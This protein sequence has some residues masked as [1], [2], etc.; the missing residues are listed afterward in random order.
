MA[1]AYGTI[2]PRK[3]S[4]RSGYDRVNQIPT[5]TLMQPGDAPQGDRADRERERVGEAGIGRKAPSAAR[6]PGLFENNRLVGLSYYS[7]VAAGVNGCATCCRT[8]MNNTSRITSMTKCTQVNKAK[9]PTIIMVI[10]RDT[11][12]SA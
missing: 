7:V 1:F 2:V 10:T 12:A 11:R 3:E 9:E 5:S 6:R 8:T 4:S